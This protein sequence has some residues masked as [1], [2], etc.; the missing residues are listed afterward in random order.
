VGDFNTTL[1][2][3]HRSWKQKLNRDTLNLTEVMKQI[4]LTDTICKTDE[5]E[6]VDTFF[7][8]IIGNKIPMV[9]VTETKFVAE[10]EGK[11]IQRLPH[12][13]IYTI[14]NHP[15]QTIADRNLV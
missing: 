9:G 3:I 5:N 10:M 12:P 2:S 11:T 6:S 4:E 13:G 15:T 1:P 14:N 7:L 8:L